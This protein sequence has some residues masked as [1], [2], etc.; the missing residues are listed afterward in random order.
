MASFKG[1]LGSALINTTLPE[2]YRVSRGSSARD[3]KRSLIRLAHDDLAKYN[4]V[5][6]SIKKIGDEF[7][8]LEGISVGLDDIEPEYKKRDPII[9]RARSKIRSSKSAK[10]IANALIEAQNSLVPI[11]LNHPGDLGLQ[12]RSGARGN[13]VQLM[14]TLASPVVV[15][16]NKGRPIPYLIERGYSEGLSPAEAWIAGDESRSQVISG[17]LGTAIPGEMSKI[18][19]TAMNSQ[20]VA[21]DDCGT[22]NGI[23]LPFSKSIGRHVAGSNLLVGVGDAG[24][25]KNKILKVRSPMTCELSR[26]VCQKCMGVG[27]SGSHSSI[28]ANVGIQAAQALSEPLTQMQL[29]AKHGVSLVEDDSGTPRKV[30]AVKQFVEVPSSFFQKAVLSESTGSV[31]KIDKAPQGGYDVTV[32]GHKMYVPPGRKLQ[33]GLGDKVEAGDSLSSG[34]PSPSE[35]VQYKGLGA[36]RKYLVES[37]GRVYDDSGQKMDQR[38]LELL[39]KSQLNFVKVTGKVPEYLPGEIISQSEFQ[40]VHKDS[41]SPIG[42]SKALGRI[43]TRPI[44][45]HL[46]GARVTGSMQKELSSAG[47]KEIHT[48]EATPE[49]QAYMTAASRT[50]LLNPNWLSRLGHRYQKR[51]L[52]DA[53]AYGH[54]AEL[55]GHD[56]I[57]GIVFGKEFTRGPRGTY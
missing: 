47:V 46:P 49:V 20:V 19:T 45:H 10:D 24:R 15:G 55:H 36:G 9:K 43:L 35:I 27:S 4:R 32:G 29:S 17:Q 51:T 50:P 28:G 48:S 5:I 42:A 25:H 21:S 14:K 41:G 38:H 52:L 53:A 22:T 31:D 8:T 37:L 1:S 34:I 44:L 12:A 18:L 11:A 56:P 30:Q 3:L 40:R 6:P 7:A 23:M 26:G 2:E 57:P 39:A 54:K 16:D 13:V 33:A